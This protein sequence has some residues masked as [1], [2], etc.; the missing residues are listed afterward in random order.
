MTSNDNGGVRFSTITPED[1]S[2]WIWLAVL[3]S[4]CY[5]I[6]FLGFR[7]IIKLHRYGFDDMLLAMAYV[8]I[9]ASHDIRLLITAPGVCH[10]TLD[11][12]FHVSLISA[13]EVIKLDDGRAIV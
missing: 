3:H 2:A 7:I 4:F 1:H 13:W 5:S 6:C 9:T 11:Y 8:S 10:W 12:H